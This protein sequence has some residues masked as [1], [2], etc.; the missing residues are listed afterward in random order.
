MFRILLLAVLCT[1]L[2][3]LRQ[4]RSHEDYKNMSLARYNDSDDSSDDEHASGKELVLRWKEHQ[5]PKREFFSVSESLEK[6]TIHESK[7]K[8]MKKSLS[9]YF[10]RKKKS[11]RRTIVH[12]LGRTV[13]LEG[14][15]EPRQ[16]INEDIE[17]VLLTGA[18]SFNFLEVESLIKFC[19]PE[20]PQVLVTIIAEY[21]SKC[22]ATLYSFGDK[23]IHFDECCGNLLIIGKE[24]L[25]VYEEMNLSAQPTRL[26]IHK[27][28]SAYKIIG[29]SLLSQNGNQLYIFKYSEDPL[30]IQKFEIRELG[31][32]ILR[33]LWPTITSDLMTISILKQEVLATPSLVVKSLGESREMT[34]SGWWITK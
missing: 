4:T 2:S 5:K 10:G 11:K 34:I 20:S 25:T 32:R 18:S 9:D 14:A 8:G 15:L 16:K 24:K 29:N 19:V 23:K 1:A 33:Q 21:L 7:N 31:I 28:A 6:C 12:D 30:C 22:I 27:R 17:K 26:R 3:P 13:S